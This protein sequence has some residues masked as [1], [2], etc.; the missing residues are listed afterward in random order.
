[1]ITWKPFT[2]K[3]II[4]ETPSTSTLVLA[5][6]IDMLPGQFIMLTDFATGEKPFAFSFVSENECGITIKS[7]GKFTSAITQVPIGSTL[8]IR[9]P[10]GNYFTLPGKD[11]KLILAGG[12]CGTAPMRLWLRFLL[13]HGYS[14]IT[15]INGAKT[16]NELLYNEEFRSYPIELIT[17]TDDG[18]EGFAGFTPDIL[19]DVLKNSSFD[20]LYTAGPEMMMKKVHEVIGNN[21]LESWFLLERY[22]KCGIGICGQ[23]T[24]DPAGIRLCIEGPVISG[25][26]LKSIDEFGAYTRDAY[27]GRKVFAGIGCT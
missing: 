2:V 4:R 27:G 5:G 20:I 21:L 14:N 18:S 16:A 22:M 19:K 17:S 6:K 13:Q 26:V 25:D 1:M 11:K 10:Y 7:V 3:D 23:C 15:F 24:L 8:Y 9:G 12:G